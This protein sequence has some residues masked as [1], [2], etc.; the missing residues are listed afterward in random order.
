LSCVNCPTGQF[1]SYDTLQCNV[2]PTGQAFDVNV[3]TCLQVLPVGQYQTN[4]NSTNLIYGGLSKAQ[5][6]SYYDT[7]RTVY[8]GIQDC[9][10]QTPY[11][12]GINCIQC[13][14]MIPY[15]ELEYRLCMTCPTGSTYTVSASYSGCITASNQQYPMGSDIAK[16]FSNIF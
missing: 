10:N 11:Y 7:N 9:P 14:S 6:Q 2:C 5:W 4:I 8:P 16:M 15:F 1:F 12:D 13:P 3:R